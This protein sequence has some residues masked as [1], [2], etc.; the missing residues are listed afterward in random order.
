MGARPDS[1]ACCID[2]GCTGTG[3]ANIL[4]SDTGTGT[5]AAPV[6][7][8]ISKTPSFLNGLKMF[9]TFLMITS[10]NLKEYLKEE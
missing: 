7:S 2:A 6:A 4:A 10:R 1:G 8:C 9:L 3:T 5:S